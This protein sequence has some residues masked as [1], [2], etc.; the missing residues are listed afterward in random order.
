ALH[1]AGDRTRRERYDKAERVLRKMVTADPRRAALRCAS[2]YLHQQQEDWDGAFDEYS[3]SRDLMPSSSETHSRLAY[4]FYRYDDGDN[5]IA[6]A[7]SALSID[8]QNAEA[9]RYLGLCP[10]ATDRS[11]G[12]LDACPQ[13]CT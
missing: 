13:S 7:R 2:G 1:Q 11:Q 9:Y 6:E 8:P 12:A 10:Y 3:D 5:A 4:I